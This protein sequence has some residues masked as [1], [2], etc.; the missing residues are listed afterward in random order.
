MSTVVE[1]NLQNSSGTRPFQRDCKNDS[2][3]VHFYNTQIHKVVFS[4]EMM[5]EKNFF[6]RTLSVLYLIYV[7][8]FT[9]IEICGARFEVH[10]CAIAYD[11]LSRKLREFRKIFR[12]GRYNGFRFMYFP[13]NRYVTVLSRVK[14]R[15][16]SRYAQHFHLKTTSRYSSVGA[17]HTA[18][19][20]LHFT[21]LDTVKLYYSSGR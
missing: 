6:Y 7:T 18:I 20:H 8:H 17:Q 12:A 13:I 14:L 15:Q 3:P 11:I 2:E 21:V 19:F 10:E 1:R 5:G 16:Y 4:I 9:I